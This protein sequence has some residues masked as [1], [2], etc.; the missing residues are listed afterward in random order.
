MFIGH[1]SPVLDSFL[2]GVRKNLEMRLEL[3]GECLPCKKT[4]AYDYKKCYEK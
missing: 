2:C 4:T 1:K 3:A